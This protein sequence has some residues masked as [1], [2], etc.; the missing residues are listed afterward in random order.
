MSTTVPRYLNRPSALRQRGPRADVRAWRFERRLPR[1]HHHRDYT[2]APLRYGVST[3]PAFR[4]AAPH[5]TSLSI[6]TYQSP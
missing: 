1:P 4:L 5:P 6:Q 3:R 2:T